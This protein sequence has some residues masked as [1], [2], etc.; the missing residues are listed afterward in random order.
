MFCEKRSN[1][2]YIPA[3]DLFDMFGEFDLLLVC[4]AHRQMFAAPLAMTGADIGSQKERLCRFFG[5]N[6]EAAEL[7]TIRVERGGYF[8]PSS[9]WHRNVLK[10][11]KGD[12][13]LF[14]TPGDGSEKRFCVEVVAPHAAVSAQLKK[15]YTPAPVLPQDPAPPA[16][17]DTPVSQSTAGVIPAGRMPV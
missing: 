13:F 16:Y 5:V 3:N 12:A 14:S 6:P 15:I 4:T 10:A 8:W 7:E 1:R 11:D 2:M 17:P 9:A